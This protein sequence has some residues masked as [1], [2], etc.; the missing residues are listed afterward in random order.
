MMQQSPR[1]QAAQGVNEDLRNFAKSSTNLDQAAARA[2]V[3]DHIAGRTLKKDDHGR[4]VYFK[5][6]PDDGHHAPPRI[7]DDD[8]DSVQH[9]DLS[10][11]DDNHH[12]GYTTL[13]H[14]Q[15]SQI[16]SQMKLD[17]ERALM[18]I[19]EFDF[20]NKNLKPKQLLLRPN[21]GRLASI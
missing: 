13:N 11:I 7:V 12:D 3:Q 8:V 6:E 15:H 5:D 20:S 2:G 1:H 9:L 10:V 16:I 18:K 4:S 21:R 19:D 17:T 14:Q